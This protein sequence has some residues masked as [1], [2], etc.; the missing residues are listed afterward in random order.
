MANRSHLPHPLRCAE[1]VLRFS[2]PSG[3]RKEGSIEA[4]FEIRKLG[5]IP[6]A[7]VFTG[8]PRACPEQ[9]SE[10]SAPNGNL[11]CTGRFAEFRADPQLN[12]CAWKS[13]L[14]LPKRN[15]SKLPPVIAA[16]AFPH[17]DEAMSFSE[18]IFLFFLALI[19]F[20]PK[21]L[22]EIARQAGRLLAELRRA[23]NEFK[24][25]IE[26][27]IAHLE[28]QQ[29]TQ[30]D[31]EKNGLKKDLPPGAIPYGSIAS[32]NSTGESAVH[33]ASATLAAPVAESASPVMT[34]PS[35]PAPASP[36]PSATPAESQASHV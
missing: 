34:P 30:N 5:G 15:S 2:R 10:A 31:A 27:E 21:K 17:Y 13:S 25:Q 18:T 22:P 1:T 24:S 4:Q 33:N 20:G 3:R 26:T 28:V 29:R 35:D 8:G 7:R 11:A 23:S 6:K 32:L 14:R 16:L 9:T 36:E 19:I 12:R